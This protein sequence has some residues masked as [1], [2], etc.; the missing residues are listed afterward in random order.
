[1]DNLILIAVSFTAGLL[2]RRYSRMPEQTPVVLNV[3]IIYV[4]LPA[5][6]LY[7]LH[8]L[9]FSPSMFLPASMPWLTFGSLILCGGL[10]NT[11]FFGFPM[12]EAFYGRQGIVHGIIIDQLGS[13]MVVSIFGVAVAGIYSHGSADARS[14]VKRV[15][16]FSLFIALIAAVLLND[17]VY[18]DWFITLIRRLSDMLA[19]MALFS[20]GFQF[21]PGHIGKSRST[22]AL[23]LAFKLAVVPAVMFLVYVMVAGM[24]GLPARITTFEAA[25]P[26]MITGGIIAAEHRL[27]PP[28]VNLM[29]SLGL[30]VSFATLAIWTLLL[31]VV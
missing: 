22:L 15:L 2:M 1:M 26:T 30:L 4:S 28:L 17:V 7:Y 29:V 23:G 8:G 10:G 25:M 20:V 6:V 18:P 19:P 12:I 31:G 13:F 5:M 14:I 11:S 24:H 3:F 27:D 21:N 9:D 16:L